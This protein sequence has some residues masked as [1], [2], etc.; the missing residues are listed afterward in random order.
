MQDNDGETNSGVTDA[1]GTFNSLISAIQAAGGPVYAFAQIDPV[2]GED[3]GAPGGNIRVGFLYNSARVTFNARPGGDA[4]TANTVDCTTG[5]PALA[6]NPG[7][8]DPTNTAFVSSRKPIVGEFEFNGE[9]IFVVGVHFNSK[10]GD[11]PLFGYLQP[12]VLGSEAQRI[13][14]AL[15]VRD[16]TNSILTCI[17]DA[18]VIVLGDVNDF[19]FSPPVSTL[20]GSIL[21]NLFDL[22]PTNQ[23][24]S[25][26]FDGNS[27]VL[28]QMVVSSYLLDHA[29]P[30][31]DVVHVNAEFTDQVSDHDPSVAQFQPVTLV[32]LDIRPLSTTNPI[33]LNSLLPVPAAILSTPTF[34]ARSV[35]TRTVTLAGAPIAT[36]PNGRLQTSYLDVNNDRL[37]DLVMLFN[38]RD[39]QLEL[40]D[41]EA[42]LL[43]KT[44]A[45]SKIRG[46]DTVR[47]V[48][49][50]ALMLISPEN[51]TTVNTRTPSFVWE[52][53]PDAVCYRIDIDNEPNF[54]FPFVQSAIVVRNTQFSAFH[55]RNGTY[56]WRVQV[57]GLCGG[58]SGLWSEVWSVVVNAP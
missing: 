13:S 36:L 19:T 45:G 38:P 46:T 47:I 35:D 10:G 5:R 15:V 26:V 27:Q 25:Y 3:G 21:H 17:P 30:V 42:V 40:S 28:D 11:T 1:T 37:A 8:I 2:N 58:S 39:F 33:N 31:Y 41:T 7:R 6:L 16:F 44:L 14:Q 48:N 4:T 56:Y 54:R 50:D 23:Q 34:S 9:P 49:S 51:G 12:P 29:A 43:G 24:Y 55:L 57:S 18:S 53:N 52:E 20:Q 32:N 22:L